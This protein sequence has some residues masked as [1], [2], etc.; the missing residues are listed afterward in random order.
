VLHEAV[1]SNQIDIV[2]RLL[3]AGASVLDTDAQDWTPLHLAAVR[4]LPD[5][6]LV[7]LQHGAEPLAQDTMGRTP[8][9]SAAR[10][11]CLATAQ[12]LLNHGAEVGAADYSKQTALHVA[13]LRGADELVALFL[14]HAVSPVAVSLQEN[15]LRMP[16]LQ[17]AAHR[18]HETVVKQLLPVVLQAPP[19]VANAV[20]SKAAVAAANN[21][22]TQVAVLLVKELGRRD[23]AAVLS[24]MDQLWT[25]GPDNSTSSAVLAAVVLKWVA[26]F[27]DMPA[28]QEQLQR[29]QQE[30]DAA[31]H[32]VQGL[33]LAVAGLMRDLQLEGPPA[34][35]EP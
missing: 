7:L 9:H 28:Q 24:F 3:S 14:S 1:W 30:L 26:D 34:Q 2:Q 11:G 17:C 20:I 27:A 15:E 8:L 4:G 13:A 6:V 29:E 5:I 16:P 25:R 18:G 12:H 31:K 22:F 10:C 35:Q 23:S 19:E 21:N 32:Q 33:C